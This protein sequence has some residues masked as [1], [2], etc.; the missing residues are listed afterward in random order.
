MEYLVQ[1][2]KYFIYHFEPAL[3]ILLSSNIT[4]IRHQYRLVSTR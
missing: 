2:D 4:I 3:L 1:V